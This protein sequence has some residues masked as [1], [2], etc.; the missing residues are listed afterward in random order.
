V[1]LSFSD[2]PGSIRLVAED[3]GAGTGIEQVAF[4][5]GT[6]WSKQQLESAYIAQQT[7][8]GATNITG[9]DQNND[10]IVGTSGNDTLY[11]LGGNDT[12]TGGAGNDYLNGGGGADTYIYSSADGNDVIEDST[13]DNSLVLQDIASTAVVL[14][15]PGN[16]ADL[17]IENTLTGNTITVKG[18]FTGGSLST[19]T[20]SD[21]VSWSSQNILNIVASQPVI[22]GTDGAETINGTPNAETID[23]RGGDDVLNGGA[24]GDTYIF[25]VGSGNDVIQ[26]AGTSS[27]NDVVKLVGLNASD[28]DI[29][30]S[31]NDLLIRILSSGETLKVKDQF[32][33]P[34][35]G[36]ELLQFGASG[37]VVDVR[38]YV[39]PMV[40]ITGVSHSGYGAAQT[41][42]GTVVSG[43]VAAVAGQSVTLMDNG[44]TVG[45]ATVQ[46]NGTFSTSI[47]LPSLSANSIVAMVTD[48]YGN[49]G[50]SA[51]VIDSY[52]G[53][54]PKISGT[55]AGQM[56]TSEAP[57]HPFSTVSIDD[58]N[59]GATDTLTITL[60]G[61]GGTL[62]G[63]GLSG[64]N[65]VY[66]L[67]GSASTITDQLRALTFAPAA[68]LPNTSATTTFTLSDSSTG[69]VAPG[70][71]GITV[72]ASFNGSNGQNPV[73]GLVMDAAGN[74]F[75][76]SVYT[77][78]TL[79]ELAKSGSGW[80][81]SLTTLASLGSANSLFV[82][83]AGN[84]FGAGLSPTNNAGIVYELAKNGSGWNSSVTTLASF[85][86]ATS[87]SSPSG[88][89]MDGAGNLFGT[90]QSGGS[91]GHGTVYEIVKTGN[92]YN[93]TP[94]VLASF[95]ISNGQSP[96]GQLILD[97]A[98]NL[99]GATATT[100]FEI[101]KSGGTY[102]PMTVLSTSVQGPTG[103]LIMDAAGNLYGI[104]GSGG[105][106][107][108]GA[109]YELAKTGNGYSSTPIV[110]ASFPSA[111]LYPQGPLL[112]DGAGNLYGVSATSSTFGHGSIFKI[113][114][115]ADGYDSTPV[116]LSTFVGPNG[117]FP[118][119]IIMDAAG[120]F[121]GEA[122][123]GG[124][125]GDG[126]I[127]KLGVN[128]SVAVA[129]ATADSTTTVTDIDPPVSPTATSSNLAKAS[130]L[131]AA[132]TSAPVTSADPSLEG[133]G[134]ALR[135][136]TAQATN[137][138]AENVLLPSQSYGAIV[139]TVTDSYGSAGNTNGSAQITIPALTG[140]GPVNSLDLT[141]GFTDREFVFHHAG[142]DLAGDVPGTNDRLSVG[143]WMLTRYH[144]L[145]EISAR[146]LERDSQV[147]QL[148]QAMATYSANDHG[149]ALTSSGLSSVPNDTSL[150]NTIA[151]AWHT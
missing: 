94:T 35:T 147:S 21:G 106:S 107:N 27:D 126:V 125:Y 45:T 69:Y 101:P 20:F 149:F 72:L 76:S 1:T 77:S 116:T 64:S 139:P 30:R 142:N 62:S 29:T 23:G 8:A 54:L 92:T 51:A 74:L 46:A 111:G 123:G 109:V 89:I 117:L 58:L 60:S 120:N 87:G 98:G 63:T 105:A 135:S 80:S 88:V 34:S 100:V 71:G 90:A 97:S 129:S 104:E 31:G 91:G 11:G 42:S 67:S 53:V 2:Q 151:A 57:V 56:T 16:G 99:F 128:S 39:A 132:I 79:F 3:G 145:E 112:M 95:N 127:F 43:G 50:K 25:R 133:D 44:V 143:D 78:A 110:L 121:F 102:G 146:C 114:K 52:A 47:A 15:R 9:F 137:G 130:N 36:V 22:L 28:V 70:Y 122:Q 96:F 83:A 113:V 41:I 131:A 108:N 144:Q 14:S 66:T 115:T 40:T 55:V 19:V 150:Q 10:V 124:A 138:F 86:A 37:A 17:I 65:G 118:S 33:G 103:G 136:A 59:V 134:V 81:N 68:G 73:G 26:E 18:Q 12:L 13:N 140:A 84:L 6:V 119:Q 24:G 38:N 75:G 4:G 82:D 93:S 85:T 32:L 141:R 5:D 61:A 48:S 7:A 49:I 148:V